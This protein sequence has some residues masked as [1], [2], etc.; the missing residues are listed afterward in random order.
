MGSYFTGSYI[1]GYVLH[2]F[3]R[4]PQ[5]VITPI[6]I[7]GATLTLAGSINDRGTIVDSY[8]DTNGQHGF[9]RSPQGAVTPFDVPGSTATRASSIN[10]RGAVAGTYNDAKTGALVGFLRLP[11]SFES[12]DD[13]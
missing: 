7:P 1:T 9:V 10:N 11:A 13:Q 6:G 5:G 8:I 4:S 12:E 2:S 3:V